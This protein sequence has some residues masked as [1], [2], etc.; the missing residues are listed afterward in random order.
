MPTRGNF[1]AGPQG[2]PGLSTGVAGG[3]LGGNF[4]NPTLQNTTNVQSAVRSNSLDQ[5]T[6]P[7]A[8]VNMNSKK[9]TNL[10]NGTL[11]TDAATFGQV[12]T[13]LPPSGSAGGDL[14]GTY[15]N[16][17]L[18]TTTNVNSIIRAN[19]LD[20]LTPA[21]APVNLNGQKIINLATGT[22]PADGATFGQIPIT[23]PPSGTATGDLSGTYPAPTLANTSNVQSVVRTNRL[24]Q[25]A[26]PIASVAMSGKKFTGMA[27]G[28]S[29]TDSAAFGQIPLSLPP[30][31]PATGDL[32]GT[33][34]AP[35]LGNTANVQTVVRSNRLDQ[36]AAPTATVSM[37][38]QKLSNVGNA[39]LSTDAPNFGQVVPIT[40]G[41]M[42]GALKFNY[43]NYMNYDA[44]YF[45][46]T[47]L[48]T[49]IITGGVMSANVTTPSK[50]DIAAMTGIL[51]DYTDPANPIV[52]Q[53]STPAQTAITL[54]STSRIVT[55][56]MV[57]ANGNFIQ[58]ATQPTPTQRRTNI[59]LGITAYSSAANAI[60]NVQTTPV[61]DRQPN[62][63]LYD[64]LYSL[65]PFSITGNAVSANGANLSW[66]KSA[67]TLFSAGFNY[68]L[69]P[70]NPHVVSSAGI[71]APNF[72]YATQLTGSQSL[73]QTNV[74][75]VGHF[76]SG[77]IIT[78]IGG[79]T[80]TCSIHRVFQFATNLPGEQF[81]IQYGQATYSS[82]SAAQAAIGL[83]PF[84]V[85]PDFV[86]IGVL[87]AYIIA[88]KSATALNNAAQA[89]F[90]QPTRF[91]TP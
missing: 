60:F 42:T 68:M 37:N 61:I 39:T 56:W 74:L 80:N 16:P 12:P 24:D 53:I 25:M 67:G 44:A 15:P 8:N 36:M 65:G 14:T 20:Q 29:A 47:S 58:Q 5:M 26:A 85:N 66:N 40:G 41:T 23:L 38:S 34:P 10:A 83:E 88:T 72:R 63:Q 78:A 71:N 81:A 79:G 13:T 57:D 45:N 48:T 43:S 22:A 54:A 87:I 70:T 84:I 69:S 59:Q 19:R 6:V 91:A 62:N 73:T 32:T 9:L 52:K 2:I 46:T 17:T 33:Y 64:L 76:D 4:P 3:D 7:A 82:L 11:S 77:G 27:N 50:V 1:N 30:N 21:N 86:G 89:I 49:G 90:I 75:D 55:W 35:I 31:G 28:T 51:V 18:S